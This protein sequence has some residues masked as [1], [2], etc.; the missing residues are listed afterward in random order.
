MPPKCR[1]SGDVK[2]HPGA[3]EV[4]QPGRQMTGL[5]ARS[6]TASK[7]L[8]ASYLNLSEPQIYCL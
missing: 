7:L 3:T 6:A 1:W 4:R 2:M 5:K 8:V